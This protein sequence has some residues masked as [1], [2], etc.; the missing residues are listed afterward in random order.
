MNTSPSEHLA[1]LR[2]QIE[3]DIKSSTHLAEI[4]RDYAQRYAY[5][6]P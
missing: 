2:A 3:Y 1:A 4:R 5:D 6:S